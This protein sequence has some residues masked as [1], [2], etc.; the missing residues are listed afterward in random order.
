MDPPP[1]STRWRVQDASA[2]RLRAWSAESWRL[3]A[4]PTKLCLYAPGGE[5]L[6]IVLAA[7]GALGVLVATW[8][9]PRASRAAQSGSAN[10]LTYAPLWFRV[11]PIS[12]AVTRRCRAGLRQG[13]RGRG[14]ITA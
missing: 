4:A 6:P 11:L 2:D 1:K 3:I 12:R 7:P 5:A 8:P 9:G 13:P 10:S 14:S